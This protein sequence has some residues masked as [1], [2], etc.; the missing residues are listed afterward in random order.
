MAKF[1]TA[2]ITGA[3]S[4]LGWALARHL[5]ERGVAVGVLARREAKL[6]ELVDVIRATGG[7][8]EYAVVDVADRHATLAAI[9]QLRDR[10]GPID[11]LIANSGIGIPT[12]LHPL[13]WTA[14]DQMVRVN[15]LGVIYSLE[16]VLGDMLARQRGHLAAISSLA[17]MTGL[18][19]ESGYCSS[20]AAVNVYLDGL[21]VALR[22]HNIK[23]TTVCPG[24]I[25]TP[26]TEQHHFKMPFLLSAEAAARRI[27]RALEQ[28][29]KVF[30]FPW[31]T[32]LL[33]RLTRWM[34]DWLLA[35]IMRP[36][37]EDRPPPTVNPPRS[38]QGEDS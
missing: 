13:D 14:V 16:A 6:Q 7:R 32:A 31:Q 17:G 28:E 5:A 29:K 38:A 26:M 4:G 36:Y 3:S 22:K 20:K 37:T 2:V 15:Y 35:R 11:L 21:R 34:P 30:N 18:P 27:V 10:L 24:F 12:P 9:A 1:A 8:A 19:G 25:T 23:V 33:M